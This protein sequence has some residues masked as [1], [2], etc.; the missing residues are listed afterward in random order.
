MILLYLT[1]H[2]QHFFCL[3]SG[4]IYLPLGISLS[5]SFVTVSELYYCEFFKTF[6]ILSGILLPI[7]SSV[8]SAVFRI[9]LFKAVLNASVANCLA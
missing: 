3:S 8:D 2:Y 9:A 4:D 1:L 6:V 7:K 5:C